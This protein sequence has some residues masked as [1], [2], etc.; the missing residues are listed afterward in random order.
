MKPEYQFSQEVA[1]LASVILRR[2]ISA[3]AIDS[4]DIKDVHKSNL[5]M[6]L[7]DNTRL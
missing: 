5:W 3:S 7:N 4:S 6:R 2:N 1:S